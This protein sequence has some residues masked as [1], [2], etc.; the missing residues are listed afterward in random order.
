MEIYGDMP[1]PVSTKS[2]HLRIQQR[3]EEGGSHSHPTYG[4]ME[5][6]KGRR[7]RAT[8][9]DD[10]GVDASNAFMSVHHTTLDKLVETSFEDER[11]RALMKQRYRGARIS[12]C[13][14]ADE[15]RVEIVPSFGFFFYKETSLALLFLTMSTASTLPNGQIAAK[16][17]TE[18]LRICMRSVFSRATFM[19]H[20]RPFF[21]D[22]ITKRTVTKT[23]QEVIT[24]VGKT[25]R[26][27]KNR[28]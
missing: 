8:W 14:N 3:P 27:I 25:S 9:Y 4:T 10:D 5:T 2:Q 28:C 16:R 24:K 17:R 7:V 1:T 12:L 19:M 18:I 21:A 13:A 26:Q 20:H 11:D 22:D 6:D 23:P 15:P